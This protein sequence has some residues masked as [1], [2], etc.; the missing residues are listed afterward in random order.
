MRNILGE[1][2]GDKLGTCRQYLISMKTPAIEPQSVP[3]P[4]VRITYE[5]TTGDTI[6]LR[7]LP[8]VIGILADL[9][10]A[11]EHPVRLREK[12]F[13]EVD[14]DNLD[15]FMSDLTPLLRFKVPLTISDDQDLALG[16]ELRFRSV[17]DFEP[18]AVARQVPPLR[19]MLETRAH[20]NNLLTAIHAN[21]RNSGRSSLRTSVL[22]WRLR[23]RCFTASPAWI[24]SGTSRNMRLSAG[25]GC[26]T[27]LQ[28]F[29]QGSIETTRRTETA[30]SLRIAELDRL[31]S[32]QLNEILH[33]PDFQTLEASW[34]GLASLVA[35][36]EP[37]L[38]VKVRV[39]SASKRELLKDV[40]SA[41]EFDT[42][43][44]FRKIHDEEYG[45]F[46]GSTLR[47]SHR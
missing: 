34:R 27:F 39:L 5:V 15:S 42:S 22:L 4:R 25:S 13:V 36:F 29:A 35:A 14:R 1:R 41:A 32:I 18:L 9:Q 20:L 43:N 44:L 24:Y 47:G 46:G 3:S 11:V 2:S 28:E 33:H 45:T 10:G 37:S 26:E 19:R 21:P 17:R 40:D 31:V 6:E 38:I 12:R 16:V 23:R 8:F 7:E 30:L